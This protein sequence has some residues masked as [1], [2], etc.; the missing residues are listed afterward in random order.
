MEL[1]RRHDQIA[2]Q[3]PKEKDESISFAVSLARGGANA[4]IT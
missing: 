4:R 1:L 2:G 3:L